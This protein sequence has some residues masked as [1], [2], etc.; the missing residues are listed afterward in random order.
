M[1]HEIERSTSR[2]AGFTTVKTVMEYPDSGR[3]ETGTHEYIDRD[4]TVGTWFY[5]LVQYDRSGAI[6]FSDAVEVLVTS[7]LAALGV[8]T[9]FSLEQN[10][11]NPF[12]PSTVIRFGMPSG[13]EVNIT[14]YNVL[15]QVVKGLF[16]GYGEAG[17][18]EI[19][20]DGSD[21]ASGVYYY[22]LRARD[23]VKTQRMIL[24]K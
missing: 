12:N 1:K 14:V 10:Y 16:D 22:R 13:S 15:G 2:F 9:E 18:H 4:A 3:R 6:Y 5:R 11:P 20:F 8:P 21:L 7:G 19:R 24:V 17:Y 23:V